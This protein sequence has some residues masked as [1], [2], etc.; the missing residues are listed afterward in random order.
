MDGVSLAMSMV[1]REGSFQGDEGMWAEMGVGE[2][3]VEVGWSMEVDSG[4]FFRKSWVVGPFKILP[5]PIS[6]L[7]ESMCALKTYHLTLIYNSLSS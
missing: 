3:L 7:L 2:D 1:A 5:T 6:F 4:F